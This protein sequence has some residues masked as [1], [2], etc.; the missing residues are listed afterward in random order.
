M[1]A[2]PSSLKKPVESICLK[3][4]ETTESVLATLLSTYGA[5]LRRCLAVNDYTGLVVYPEVNVLLIN[6]DD[7]PRLPWYEITSRMLWNKYEFEHLMLNEFRAGYTMEIEGI[8]HIAR[9][10]MLSN[11]LAP[12]DLLNK[13]SAQTLRSIFLHSTATSFTDELSRLSRK[14]KMDLVHFL[15]L[16]WCNELIGQGRAAF[17][18][19]LSLL[20][21][22]SSDDASAVADLMFQGSTPAPIVMLNSTAN[23]TDS[24]PEAMTMLRDIAEAFWAYG[25][26]Q[27]SR[28]EIPQSDMEQLDEWAHN[29]EEQLANIPTVKARNCMKFFPC[30]LYRIYALINCFITESEETDCRAIATA[31][32]SALARRHY[33]TL[34]DTT[35]GFTAEPQRTPDSPDEMMRE[36][37]LLARIEAKQPVKRSELY[38]SCSTNRRK[39]LDQYLSRLVRDGRVA[40]DANKCFSVR[41]LVSV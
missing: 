8:Y 35:A 28:L 20:W 7:M 16:S 14:E 32:T 9:E 17:K 22:V 25:Q 4:E 21:E 36:Y 38:R 33:S 10:T 11:Q 29:F 3:T 13:W 2:L 6:P 15:K 39:E 23:N 41:S 34:H 37:E 12:Y 40:I 18:A 5:Q 27:P 1:D 31:L 30:L 26:S 19:G 24:L